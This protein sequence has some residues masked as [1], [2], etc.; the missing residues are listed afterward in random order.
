MQQMGTPLYMSPEQIKNTSEI[1]KETDYYSLGVVL[2][3]MVMA[4]KPYDSN[5]LT[6]PE[7][8]VAIMKEPLS[9]TNSIWDNLI[10]SLTVKSKENRNVRKHLHNISERKIA[11]NEYV[12]ISKKEK[13]VFSRK[14]LVIFGVILFFLIA[15]PIISKSD[16]KLEKI[17]LAEKSKVNSNKSSAD[18]VKENP[19]YKK[20]DK[21]DKKITTKDDVP[22][23][24]QE[25]NQEK[26]ND[27]DG[28][29]DI[30]DDCPR[31]Y[32][33]K[34]NKG[35]PYIEF[36]KPKPTKNRTYYIYNQNKSSAYGNTSI[37][38]IEVTDNY[39]IIY[40][41]DQLK[42]A[43]STWV[44]I[45]PKTYILDKGNNTYKD[46]LYV[47]GIEIS[48]SKTYAKKDN[49]IIKFKLYF[50]RISDNCNAIDFI[51]SYSSEW[52]F[53]GIKLEN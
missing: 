18:K 4:K 41:T 49:E 37:D 7:I 35:C 19:V 6:L 51:E 25:G 27:N 34:E 22:I 3:E 32:G 20:Q 48:P 26:D 45:D 53:Y 15:V 36:E 30:D 28:I 5:V 52:K 46:L 2:W 31:T 38:K 29:L 50:P 23:P 21:S 43:N 44:S 33:P 17:E 42:Y 12:I 40:F 14:W 10:K 39:T 47:S 24:E 16:S 8:Q 1:T 11:Q 9:I 13:R